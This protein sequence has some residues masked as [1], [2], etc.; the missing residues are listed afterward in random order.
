VYMNI[1]KVEVE[2]S[3]ETLAAFRQHKLFC[4]EGEAWLLQNDPKALHES[5]LIHE[6]SVSLQIDISGAIKNL[7]EE[8]CEEVMV[9]WRE[10]SLNDEIDLL[11]EAIEAELL[12]VNQ[13]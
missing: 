12:N 10:L 5:D 1:G 11:E 9:Y 4:E 7:S 6:I 2:I 8:E 3:K 13:K